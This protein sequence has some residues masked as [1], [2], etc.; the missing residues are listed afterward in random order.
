VEAFYPQ[1]L[2][3]HVTAVLASGGLF[4][5]RALAGNVFGAT[6]TMAAPIRYLSYSLD[7]VLLTGALM[8]MTVTR[9]YPFIDAWL[10]AKV[11][12]LVVYV[13]LGGFALKRGRSRTARLA[14]S[15]TAATIFLFII[16]IALTHNPLGIF[17]TLM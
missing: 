16:S 1:I 8:L 6:W 17:S 5:L 11:M 13:V 10:T 12:L 2:A 4:A 3:V 7:T 15:A 9:Q 14:Y